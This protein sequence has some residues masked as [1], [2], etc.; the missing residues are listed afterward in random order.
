MVASY[1]RKAKCGPRT[2]ARGQVMSSSETTVH[3]FS[4]D[5]VERLTGLTRGQ[6]RSWDR[7]GF[8]APCYGYGDRK[9]AYS[10]V[11]SFRDVVGLRTIAVLMKEYG[12]SLQ[13]L[14]KV[15]E[16]LAQ[17]G[18]EHWADTKLYVV[19][20]Q[21]HF[22]VPGTSEIEGV[23]DGQLAML[24]IIDVMNDVENRVRELRKRSEDRYGQI[25][26]HKHVVRNTPVLAGT[27]IP[28]AAI[29]RYS[30][31]GYSVEHILREYPTLTRMD[32]EA[33]L[34]YEKG[35]AQSA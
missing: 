27:R 1:F 21:V 26:R 29:R 23:W 6:L 22:R 16:R 11:Y 4:E 8:F 34:A 24:P 18:F 30:E 32:V 10:R 12:V 33:A 13:E 7:T 15:A 2:T 28:T 5:H 17:R 3:A 19:K 25:E 20:R 35:L 14:R 9:A 31:A